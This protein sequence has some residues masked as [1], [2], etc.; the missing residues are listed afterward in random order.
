MLGEGAHGK[1]YKAR[2]VRPIDSK[3]TDENINTM[4]ATTSAVATPHKRKHDD[5]NGNAILQTPVSVTSK[6]AADLTM[7]LTV[8]ES[9]VT[10]EASAAVLPAVGTFVA[11]KKIRV[12]NAAD[13]LSVDA[14][15]ELKLLAELQHPRIVHI[16][17]AFQHNANINVV[18][19][20]MEHDLEAVIKDTHIVLSISHIKTYIHALLTATSYCHAQYVLHRDIKPGNILLSRTFPYVV[21]TDFGLA[22]QFASP[23]R[24]LSP[25]ACT[26]WYRAPELLFGATEYGGA[27]D[28][29]SIGCVFGELCWRRPLFAGEENVIAQLARIFAVVGTPDENADSNTPTSW[30]DV[31][32]LPDFITFT[33]IIPRPTTQ[34]FAA[35]GND[36]CDLIRRMLTLN[37]NNR[38]TAA[39][40]L[41]HE[42]FHQPPH[43]TPLD[44]LPTIQ[45]LKSRE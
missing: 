24:R 3:E 37:P 13:G 44:K 33:P 32:T 5:M 7:T 6:L 28:V 11:I 39:D 10:P 17:E 35:L 21:L 36:G 20:A 16:Y 8:D 23:N 18:M 34:L 31:S 25:Q 19:D 9:S 41:Q 14:I 45:R 27:M 38:I 15:R 43:M 1:V 22:K 4:T 29:W 12:R 30:K 40:A 42:W 26:M 2:V